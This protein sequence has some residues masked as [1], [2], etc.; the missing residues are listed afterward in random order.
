MAFAGFAPVFRDN[1]EKRV[2]V[3]SSR[4]ASRLDTTD[5]RS[6]T[7]DG[8]KLRELPFSEEEVK[9]I[10]GEFSKHGRNASLYLNADA[11]KEAFSTTALS[12]SYLHV[13]THGVVNRTD[14]RRSALIFAQNSGSQDQLD[15][16]LFAAEAYNLALNADLVVLSSCESG[17]GSYV[18]GEGMYTL[19]RGFLYSGARSVTYSLWK[20]KDHHTSELMRHFYRGILDGSRPG[21]ALQQAKIKMLSQPE[22]SFPFSWAGFVLIG[23]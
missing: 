13:A 22:T 15:G 18:T 8:K 5:L 10:A 4:L 21:K 12:C 1:G 6:I 23:E 17:V 3:V 19:T 16:A 7:V 11:T 14:P 9:S 2:N 20:V